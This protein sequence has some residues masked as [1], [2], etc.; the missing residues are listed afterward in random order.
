MEPEDDRRLDVR[1][2]RNGLLMVHVK[3]GLAVR[4]HGKIPRVR[5]LRCEVGEHALGK[6]RAGQ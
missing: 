6:N 2:R 3:E 5:E 4:A 1:R